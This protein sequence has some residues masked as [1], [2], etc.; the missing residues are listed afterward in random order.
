MC[1]AKV[2]TRP[3]LWQITYCLALKGDILYPVGTNYLDRSVRI[4]WS[5]EER[6]SHLF[7]ARLN[8]VGVEPGGLTSFLRHCAAE[9]VW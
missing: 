8:T 9:V 5:G 6:G 3:D 2:A 7:A 1:K 4:H